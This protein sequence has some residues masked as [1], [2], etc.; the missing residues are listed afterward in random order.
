[1]LVHSDSHWAVTGTPIQNKLQDMY[2]LVK[3]IQLAPFDDAM[4]WKSTVERR[5]VCVSVCV[6]VCVCVT[7]IHVFSAS[8]SL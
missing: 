1:M 3:F 4:V 6:C 2:S 5:G 8:V 7:P